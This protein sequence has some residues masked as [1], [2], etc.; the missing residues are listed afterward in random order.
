M[1][2][3]KLGWDRWDNRICTSCFKIFARNQPR[4]PDYVEFRTDAYRNI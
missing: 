4:V 1:C 2:N 3:H